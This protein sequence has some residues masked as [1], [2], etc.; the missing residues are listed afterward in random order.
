M[1]RVIALV[2]VVFV[3]VIGLTRLSTRK[4]A[5]EKGNTTLCMSQL[6]QMRNALTIYSVDYDHT[7]VRLDS[8]DGGWVDAL[9]T[10]EYG[11][12]ITVPSFLC[13]SAAN[14]TRSGYVLNINLSG[15]RDIDVLN[16]TG[17]AYV[18]DGNLDSLSG[19]SDCRDVTPRHQVGM[20]VLFF[21]M[22]GKWLRPNDSHFN[23]E[24]K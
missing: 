20:N 15:V 7:Y 10:H 3:A 13:P 4:V 11:G 12:T 19:A 22:H 24:V 9:R 21:D 14:M 17:I 6:V 2:A 23:C 5:N 18:W 8:G 1:H 16:S